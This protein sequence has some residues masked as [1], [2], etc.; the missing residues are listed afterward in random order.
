MEATITA[1]NAAT[2]AR[3]VRCRGPGSVAGGDLTVVVTAL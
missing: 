1:P 3:V 2:V